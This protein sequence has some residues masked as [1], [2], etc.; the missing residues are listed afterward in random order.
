[1][2]RKYIKATLEVRASS[3]EVHVYN[4][5]GDKIRTHKRSYSPHSWVVEPSDMP[6]KYSDYSQWSVPFFQSWASEIGPST[7][8]VIDAM[9]E[10][11]NYPVQAFRN[12]G[13]YVLIEKS[14]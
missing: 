10:S 11:V 5:N 13:Y 7:R 3:T 6:Q 14:K 1:M 2:P 12:D 8:A 9:L 4:L